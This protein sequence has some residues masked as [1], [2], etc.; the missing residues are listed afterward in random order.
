MTRDDCIIIVGATWF[1]TF[2]YSVINLITLIFTCTGKLENESGEIESIENESGEVDPSVIIIFGDVFG[3]LFIIG[4]LVLVLITQTHTNYFE[5]DK[6]FIIQLLCHISI[7]IMNLIFNIIILLM[8]KFYVTE[9]VSITLLSI[10]ILLH[11]F[12]V[13]ILL[14]SDIV[15]KVD[16]I[17]ELLCNLV[18]NLFHNDI[19][20]PVIDNTPNAV[21]IFLLGLSDNYGSNSP[22]NLIDANIARQI[23]SYV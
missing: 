8:N 13:A 19:P 2:A 7:S 11:S 10:I 5:G 23:V 20:T 4:S 12:G 9:I 16:I 6:I 21:D 3:M 1:F 18:R 15:D 17:W 14:F 22:V